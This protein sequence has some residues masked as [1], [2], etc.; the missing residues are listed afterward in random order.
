M[1][2]DPLFYEMFQ[3]HP[4][5]FFEIAQITP[6]CPYRFESVTVKSAEKR[7]DGILYP[8]VTDQPLYFVEVQGAPDKQMYWRTSREVSTFFEQRPALQNTE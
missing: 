7:I 5:I 1:K 6:Q 8:A 4:H 3:T 2:T